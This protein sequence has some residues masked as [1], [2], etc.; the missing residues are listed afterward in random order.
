MAADNDDRMASVTDE[1]SANGEKTGWSG[2]AFFV[3]LAWLLCWLPP[4]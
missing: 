2:R 4:G 3:P 1:V